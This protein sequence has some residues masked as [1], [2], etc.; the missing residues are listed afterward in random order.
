M[1]W[2][3]AFH[4]ISVV[5]WFAALFYL[6]RLYVYHSESDDEISLERFKIMERR[7]YYGIMWPSAIATTFFGVAMLY[8]GWGYYAKAH[9]VHA[10]LFLVLMLWGYHFYC[11]FL[12]KQIAENS[13]IHSTYF[14]RI[15]NELPTVFL[16]GIVILAVVKPF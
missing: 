2:L 10:K 8:L 11:G 14:Y 5:C 6:P 13:A 9:W 4:I 16:L 1:L 15:I 7:L 12:R 3:K